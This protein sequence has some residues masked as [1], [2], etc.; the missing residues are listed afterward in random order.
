MRIDQPDPSEPRAARAAGPERREATE[1][2]E[3]AEADEATEAAAERAPRHER[4]EEKTPITRAD[5]IAAHL[6]YQDTVRAAD[7]PGRPGHRRGVG[8]GE[9]GE[10]LEP[11]AERGA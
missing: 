4:H 6:R 11:G 10:A 5:Q 3:A 9:L 8:Q 1:A 2:A 7:L